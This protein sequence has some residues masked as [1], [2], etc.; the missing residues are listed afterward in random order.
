MLRELVNEIIETLLDK[1]VMII[2]KE[3]EANMRGLVTWIKNF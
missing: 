3:D 2:L 1:I